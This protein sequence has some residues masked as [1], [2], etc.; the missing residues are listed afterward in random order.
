MIKMDSKTSLPYFSVIIPQK[1]RAEYLRWTLRTCIIQDYPNLEIIVSDDCSEDNS[2]EVVEELA[3]QDSR[4]KL[5]AHKQHLGMRENFEFALRQ[6]KPGYVIALGGDDGLVPGSITKM[7][8]IL[9]KTGAKL[10]TWP[11][12]IFAYATP[13]SAGRNIL[14]VK[15]PKFTGVKMLKSKDF[16][17]K[18][19]RTF[20][21]QINECPMFYM[22]GVVST[23]LIERVKSR[24]S[25]GYFYYCPTPDGFSGVALAGEVEEYAYTYEPLSIAGNTPKS[26]GLNYR[27]TDEKS[28]FEAQQFF[29]DNSRK[30]MHPQLAS[31]PYSPLET[32]MTADYLLTAADLP[33]WP[34]K[35]YEVSFEQLIRQ[36]F[37]YLEHSFYHKDIIVRELN[38]LR[39]I[40]I[41]HNLH[42]LFEKLL[43]E[44]RKVAA[45]APPI[46]GT[47]ITNS[48]RF[49][50]SE[51][52]I[53]NIYDASLVVNFL[54][55]LGDKISIKVPFNILKRQCQ[56][57]WNN[58]IVAKERFPEI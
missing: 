41:Q 8:N 31:Q 42:P 36:T 34:G 35:C 43:K 15:R 18:I 56:I 37:N 30:M 23:D 29:Q 25:D 52:G 54:Y 11:L 44:G 12:A 32:L 3:R 57:V 13:E 39:A 22:K 21:Y 20:I 58:Y 48:L 55:N 50:G 16:L 38:I 5:F 17:Q 24:T 1:D 28:K 9:K 19:A 10:L 2:V 46:F 51:L 45:P 47:T 26:Q 49:D 33:G 4:I 53:N 40:A 14:A 6:V 27:R 7:Y